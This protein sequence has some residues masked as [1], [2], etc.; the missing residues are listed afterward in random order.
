MRARWVTGVR[1]RCASALSKK[2]H[3]RMNR[4]LAYSSY[5]HCSGITRKCL[6]HRRAEDDT[7]EP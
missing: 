2:T 5:R 1:M 3:Q 4:V 7:G 6:S